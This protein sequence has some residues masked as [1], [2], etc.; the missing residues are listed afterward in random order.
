MTQT[1]ITNAPTKELPR[2]DKN[3]TREVIAVYWDKQFKQFLMKSEVRLLLDILKDHGSAKIELT[4]ISE[5]DY[6]TAFGK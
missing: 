3:Q 5:M 6:K 4:R 2:Y 1:K